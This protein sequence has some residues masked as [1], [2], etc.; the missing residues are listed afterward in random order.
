MTWILSID[1]GTSGTKAMVVGADDAI[2]SVV[3]I[4]IRPQYRQG[5]IVEQDP[6]EL[7]D[8]VMVA[9]TRAIAEAGVTIDAVTLTNQGET[10]LAWDPATGE[11]LTSMLVWQDSRASEICEP[12]R[13]HAGLIAA[14]TGLV[15]DPY[16]SAPKLA[17]LRRHATTAG[18]V[19]TSDAWLLHH[20]TG[21]YVTDA[22]T[23]SRSLVT[24]LDTVTYDEELLALFGLHGEAMPRIVA[25]DEIVG[26]TSRFGPA[27]PVAGVVV[28]Q[29]AALLA[30]RCLTAGEAKCTFGTGAFLL[31]N[32]GEHATRSTSGL[33][34]SVAWR[35]D[36]RT[37]YCSDGQVYTAA[38][39]I[40]WLGDVG[41]LAGPEELDVLTTDDAHGAW[42][43]P[44]MAGLAAPWWRP[45]AQA[46]FTGISLATTRADLVTAVLQ[47]LA[48]Q[49]AELGDLVGRDSGQPLAR[50]RVDGGLTRSARFM[51]AVADIAQLEI[52]VY[53]SAHA[54]P[55]GA[56]ALA[57]KALDP[58]RDL[59]DTI[60]AWAPE[61]TFTPAWS[62]DRAG[63]FREHWH[64]LADTTGVEG[65]TK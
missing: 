21:E 47:G 42:C 62:A 23:A 52:D 38:S 9:A 45:D 24:N 10:V 22:S 15:L 28:D 29:Q 16:F 18:V 60:V 7:L 40:R 63:T 48:A 33:T 37:S 41:L 65:D 36:G 14:R 2:R 35:V 31:A 34:V 3:E 32:L 43:V 17:W 58:A 44:A 6:A 49:V 5:G 57:R 56:V 53:P 64:R 51:Q 59:A 54:T 30:E 4:P 1:Q 61:R 13:E 50:L 26:E 11:P 12:L 19:S 20:L 55:L 46:L 25:N 39:A 8:S 27:V